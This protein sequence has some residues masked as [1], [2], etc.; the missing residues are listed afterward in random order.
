MIYL[1]KIR[2]KLPFRG[3]FV[4]K[5]IIT[6]ILSAIF[7]CPLSASAGFYG[8]G[9]PMMMMLWPNAGNLNAKL[10]EFN[11]APLP[12]T[13]VGFGGYGF[14]MVGTT[15]HGGFG[16]GG[17][18]SS[19]LA[20]KNASIK[21]DIGSYRPGY[22]YQPGTGFFVGVIVSIGGISLDMNLAQS[23]KTLG[24]EILKNPGGTPEL[25]KKENVSKIKS[26]T[27]CMGIGI[28]THYIAANFGLNA[29]AGM[30]FFPASKWKTEAG[31]ELTDIPPVRSAF[32]TDLGLLFGG[33]ITN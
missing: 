11:Y 3:G 21:Y 2:I 9:G 17:S 23:Q 14:G 28:N 13:W 25:P 7:I 1:M 20:D 10:A 15:M 5:L 33:G 27:F 8:G 22:G 6:L 29:N 30:F 4:K 24:E 18:A 31:D 32:F 26:R 19:R 12:K 16:A